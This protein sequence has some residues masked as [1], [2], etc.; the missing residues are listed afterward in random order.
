F[1]RSIFRNEG[2]GVIRLQGASIPAHL[3]MICFFAIFVGNIFIHIYKKY[4]LYFVCYLFVLY[5]VL[6]STGSRT[7]LLCSVLTTAIF[8]YKFLKVP[9]VTKLIFGGASLFL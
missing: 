6:Y 3:G 2:N 4:K 1:N 5:I 8:A 9:I 7:A